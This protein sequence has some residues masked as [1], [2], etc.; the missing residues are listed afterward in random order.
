MSQ[1]GII[2]H[3]L[4]CVQGVKIIAICEALEPVSA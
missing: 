1:N 2:Y 4:D 3:L